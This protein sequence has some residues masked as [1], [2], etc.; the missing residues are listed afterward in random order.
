MINSEEKFKIKVNIP[1]I[2]ENYEKLVEKIQIIEYNVN[3][4]W[5]T[6]Y[7]KQPNPSFRTAKLQNVINQLDASR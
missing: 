1:N 6:Y 5:F 4:C 7:H 2:L 3:S